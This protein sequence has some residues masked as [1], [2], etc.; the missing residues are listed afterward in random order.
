MHSSFA[1]Q[2]SVAQVTVDD[3]IVYTKCFDLEFLESPSQF[4]DQQCQLGQP[5]VLEKFD[6]KTTAGWARYA[7]TSPN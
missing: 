3:G 7:F 2:G 6:H 4:P 5:I 1:N